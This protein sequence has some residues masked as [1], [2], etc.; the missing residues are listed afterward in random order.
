MNIFG[1][2]Y[3]YFTTFT[4]LIIAERHLS[5]ITSGI[6]IAPVYAGYSIVGSDVTYDDNY[7][8]AS[9]PTE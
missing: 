6:D 3:N 2:Q 1:P 8:M 7:C 5:L 9:H 4:K